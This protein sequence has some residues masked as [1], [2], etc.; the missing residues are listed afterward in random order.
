MKPDAIADILTELN[1]TSPEIEGSLVCTNDGN[2]VA[3]V[4]NS[5]AHPERLS[6]LVSAL[7]AL[8]QEGI[9]MLDR[10]AFEQL[11]VKGDN[12]YLLLA[13]AGEYAVLAIQL[14]SGAKPGLVYIDA[15][16]AGE[17]IGAQL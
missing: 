13:P 9:A 8:G 3:S 14:R 4:I 2:T 1:Q 16:R 7:L 15:R 11:V 17:S 6:A 5:V 10:G 12:G